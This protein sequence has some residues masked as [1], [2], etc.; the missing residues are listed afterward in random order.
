MFSGVLSHLP[1]FQTRKALVVLDLQNDF[2]SPNGKLPVSNASGFIESIKSLAAAFRSVG[3][4]VWTRTEFQQSRPTRDPDTDSV[5]IVLDP[6]PSGATTPIQSSPSSS[7][8]NQARRGSAGKQ[9][10]RQTQRIRP[11]LEAFL[12][13]PSREAFLSPPSLNDGGCCT[14]NSLGSQFAH[15]LRAA[16]DHDNDMVLLKSDYSAFNGTSLLLS[17]RMKL[18]TELYLAGSIS[19][20]S[21]YATALDAVRHGFTVTI[22]EDCVGYRSEA[23]HTEAMRLMADF[24]G[25]NGI[26]SGELMEELSGQ[27][28]PAPR[29][30]EPFV[31]FRG[32]A[33][34]VDIEADIGGLALAPRHSIQ[35][36]ESFHSASSLHAPPSYRSY[37]SSIHSTAE[38]EPPERQLTE[39]EQFLTTTTVNRGGEQTVTA[40]RIAPYGDPERVQRMSASSD[41]TNQSEEKL[42]EPRLRL[43]RIRM[44]RTK[45]TS[46]E[47]KHSSVQSAENGYVVDDPRRPPST[48]GSSYNRISTTSLPDSISEVGR[49]MSTSSRKRSPSSG[50]GRAK[51][52]KRIEI[53]PLGPG[54]VIGEGDSRVIYNLLPLP[55]DGQEEWFKTLKE[56]VAWQKMYHQTGE[57]PRLVAVQGQVEADG[58]M[59]IYRHPADESPPLL[60]FSN[61]VMAIKSTVEEAI[62]HPLNHVLIQL[63]RTGADNISDHSDKTLDIV[64]GSNI[65]NVS[66][67]AERAMTLRT[68]KVSKWAGPKSIMSGL[69]DGLFNGA[70][71]NEEEAPR[72]TQRVKMPHN[73]VFVLGERTNQ[74]WLHS[75]RADKRPEFMKSADEK[76][77]GGERI[78]LT[79]RHIGTFLNPDS[80]Q[81]WGQ[82]AR[83][84]ARETAGTIIEGNKGEVDRMIIAFGKE[85]HE[86]EFDW[87][88][89]YGAGFDVVNFTTK[90]LQK[91]ASTLHL[92][93]SRIVDGQIILYLERKGIAFEQVCAAPRDQTSA[94][95]QLDLP[96]YI[97][98][99]DPTI[100][101]SGD[102]AILIYLQNTVDPLPAASNARALTCV[103]K[104]K[105]LVQLWRRVQVSCQLDSG[106]TSQDP[107]SLD[108][109]RSLDDWENYARNSTS[110]FI[111]GDRFTVA[112]SAFYPLLHELMMGWKAFDGIRYPALRRYRDWIESGADKA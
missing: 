92:S 9:K 42:G 47:S 38:N 110:G 33:T 109:A 25:V 48:A 93:G 90:P 66:I 44:R 36:A 81:I 18:V 62:H 77:Y 94:L 104:A 63:Y 80:R 56:E 50:D 31:R 89:Q 24:L 64:R 74:R 12:S 57:V 102:F 97:D 82:G 61:T 54:D 17:L 85:N 59:P 22:L 2:V 27:R 26:T 84:K 99:A 1:Q 112:D 11:D 23:R 69:T 10:P 6:V 101:V 65:V 39:L 100:E 103:N 52:S 60:P 40:R 83:S 51:A 91:T 86:T 68:K 21:V 19:N 78:S 87:D 43:N 76:A 13:V 53:V 88:R 96:R 108:I 30:S 95:T 3:D 29:T 20:V 15:S 34:S 49:A 79:F 45:H 32:S 5:I 16:I 7:M 8:R 67:G 71:Q 35:S 72:L 58:S 98:A 106:D 75:I 14:P 55:V 37:Q 105:D 111:V 70:V 73:S 107:T 41:V 4:V 28:V 46:K